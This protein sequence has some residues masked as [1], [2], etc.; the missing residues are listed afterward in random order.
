M[1]AGRVL[2]NARTLVSRRLDRE[3]K[4]VDAVYDDELWKIL[5]AYGLLA[6]LDAGELTCQVTGVKLTRDNVGGLIGSP[7]GPRLICDAV[8]GVESAG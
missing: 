6:K 2:E 3:L 7:D 8:E 4:L 5:D 1:K